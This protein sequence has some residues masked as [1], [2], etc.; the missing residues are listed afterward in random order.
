VRIREAKPERGVERVE[1]ARPLVERVCRGGGTA[2]GEHPLCL[3]R[4]YPHIGARC[5]GD[6]GPERWGDA[7]GVNYK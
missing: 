5:V 3:I 7:V 2:L 6:S 4:P 1:L